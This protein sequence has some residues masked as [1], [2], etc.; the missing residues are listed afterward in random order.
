MLLRNGDVIHGGRVWKNTDVRLRGDKIDAVGKNLSAFEDEEIADCT[1]KY[2]APGYIDIHVHGGAG[3]RFEGTAEECRKVLDAHTSHGTTTMFPT[4]SAMPH[5]QLVDAVDRLA[6]LCEKEKGY[7]SLAGIHLEGPY[8]N[9]EFAGAMEPEYIQIPTPDKYKRLLQS[10][11]VKR[12]SYAPELDENLGMTK[13]LAGRGVVG[14]IG[15]SGATIELMRKVLDMGVSLITH[16][17]SAMPVVYRKNAFR[18][19]GIPEAAYLIDEFDVE[20]IADGKHLPPDLLALIYKIKGTGHTAIIT[21]GTR[22]SA[23]GDDAPGFAEMVKKANVIVQD[24][25]AFTPDMQAFSGSITSTDKL[26]PNMVSMANTS[27]PDAVKML[28]ETPARIMGLKSKGRIMAGLDADVVVLDR[29]YAVREVIV[30][31]KRLYRDGKRV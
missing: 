6:E 11:Y 16:L 3:E 29:E 28:T 23:V 30:M 22:A 12:I 26:V 1:G 2:I 18:Y 19:M 9:P 10:P 5:D 25:V 17:Y 31:G 14:A 21:D 24:G 4:L 15:H 13:Y 8:L 7:C 20:A 27:L